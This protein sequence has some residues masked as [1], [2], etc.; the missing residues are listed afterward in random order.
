MSKNQ[1]MRYEHFKCFLKL[2]RHIFFQE[3]LEKNMETKS[4]SAVGSLS[5]DEVN[6]SEHSL[7]Q[8][9]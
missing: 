9:D 8:L 1:Y 5:D 7:H 2:F 4:L 6:V 3:I